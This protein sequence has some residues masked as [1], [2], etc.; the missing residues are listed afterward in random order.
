MSLDKIRIKIDK[1]DDQLVKLLN[2][3]AILALEIGKIKQNK[4]LP[5][6]DEGREKDILKRISSGNRGP[7]S[8]DSITKI[9]SA[10]I[11][12]NRNLQTFY[13][14]S[15]NEEKKNGHHNGGSRDRKGNRKRD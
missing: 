14:T 12:E 3:R 10:I 15:I 13:L 2:E 7:L 9:F 5:I 11:V 4:N 8:S 1:L 6:Y